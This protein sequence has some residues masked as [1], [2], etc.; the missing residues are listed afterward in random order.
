MSFLNPLFLI[1]LI[2]VG[3]PLLIYLLNIR[4][5]K[6]IRFS[7]L[8][9]FD[10]LKSSS[11]R[12]IKLKRWLLLTL[13]ILAVAA[14]ALALAR[15]FLPSGLGLM[16]D[17]EPAVVGIVIDNGPAMEQIDRHGPYIEQ[18]KDLASEIV[19]MQDSDS[20]FALNVS[21]GESLNLPLLTKNAANRELQQIETLNAGNYFEENIKKSIQQLLSEPEPNKIL[22]V[23]TD[24]QESLLTLLR[25]LEQ[26]N[27]YDDIQVKVIKIGEAEPS[28]AGIRDVHIRATDSGN[29]IAATVENYGS[30]RTGNQFFNFFLD[31]ELIAQQV[32][33]IE[34]WSSRDFQFEIPETDQRFMKA[35]LLI[36][37][38]EFS[39]DNRFYAAIQ[40]PEQR[41]VLVVNDDATSGGDFRSYLR[42][43]LEAV[44]EESERLVFEFESVGDLSPDRMDEMDAIVL[45]GVRSVPDYLS[46]AIIDNVQSG[47]GLL[48]LPASDGRIDSYNRL[49]GI[50]NAGRYSDLVGS[51]GSFQRFD[52]LA[53][54]QQGHPILE[55][56]FDLDEG[57]ELRVNLP[58]LFYYYR[59]NA[60]DGRASS[61]VLTSQTGNVILNETAVGNGKL[62]YSAIGSDPGW[63]NFPIKPLFAPLF[64]RTVE[65][66]ASGE[67]PR[68][69]NHTLGE[70]FEI[71]MSDASPGN[72]E[73]MVDDQPIIPVTR[74]TFSGLHI[75]FRGVEWTPGWVY[76]NIGDEE[77][78]YAVN[79]NAMESSLRSLDEVEIN[80]ILSSVFLNYSVQMVDGDRELLISEL[81]TASFG[82]EIWYWFIIVAIFLLLTESIVSRHYKAETIT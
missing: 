18:V 81:E 80:S 46:Q 56:M 75:S 40:L 55:A 22:Y 24:G 49:L 61:P 43:L 71:T 17:G 33:D 1:A 54:P 14:L 27:R 29:L 60:M 26:D 5:P 53:Q 10:S 44:S 57:E 38:D 45:D 35:E 31:G 6:R 51:Y 50:S 67:G 11:L 48:L 19:G 78:L 69:N 41:R 58:E 32:Y 7:T 25:G 76:V 15:P 65:Y 13:R 36:E 23:L 28:N 8:A 21:H 72:I 37:G 63:S 39:F 30:Q 42:P 59:I 70:P 52:Q 9:F 64:Y 34:A 82:R 79:Q 68:L 2:S 47:G 20:R 16:A 74:Q 66:L 4:K 73:L 12:K 3:I 77:K 62:I